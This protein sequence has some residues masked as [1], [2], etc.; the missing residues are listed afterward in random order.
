MVAYKS[1]FA[2]PGVCGTRSPRNWDSAELGLRGTG[3]PR[4]QDRGTGTA[5]LGFRGTG[6]IPVIQ[7]DYLRD[8]LAEEETSTLATGRVLFGN[9]HDG[10]WGPLTPRWGYIQVFGY[11]QAFGCPTAATH[12]CWSMPGRLDRQ[13]GLRT[14]VWI[15]NRGY[16]RVLGVQ[17][18]ATHGC[19]ESQLRLHTGVWNPKRAIVQVANASCWVHLLSVRT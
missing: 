7:N 15:P 11:D 9:L 19:L 4:N 17:A 13:T 3:S 6:S 14:G 5:E 12:R 2:E 10:L 1:R 16:T 8:I 18:A